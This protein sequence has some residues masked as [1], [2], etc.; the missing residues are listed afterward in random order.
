M[1]L[2]ASVP[3]LCLGTNC[4]LLLLERQ[5]PTCLLS[6]E[7]L[8]KFSQ[9]GWSRDLNQ[10]VDLRQGGRTRER[11][12]I[13][14]VESEEGL[15]D[16]DTA[17][18]DRPSSLEPNTKRF[19]TCQTPNPPVAFP[20]RR[21]HRALTRST[22]PRLSCARP[23]VCQPSHHSGRSFTAVSAAVTAGKASC[24]IV[25]TCGGMSMSM[26]FYNALR[27]DSKASIDQK[28]SRVLHLA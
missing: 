28:A 15:K 8:R 11:L 19:S 21:Y 22:S 16:T 20:S 10:E 4:E 23:S 24:R 25:S 7:S 26:T 5:V 3:A 14:Q 2:V 9:I 27:I 17:N 6:F 12:V 1:C 13:T 18:N